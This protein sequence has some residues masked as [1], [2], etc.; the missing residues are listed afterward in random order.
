M[1]FKLRVLLLLSIVV[2]ASCENNKK[3]DP[4]V[5]KISQKNNLQIKENTTDDSSKMKEDVLFLIDTSKGTHVCLISEIINN[6]FDTSIIVDF[7]N[8]H[9][10]IEAHKASIIEGNY[11][12]DN[13]D[14]ITDITNDYYITNVNSKLRKFT[15][16][17]K[18][19]LFI[20]DFE[21]DGEFKKIS[22]TDFLRR[23]NDNIDFYELYTINFKNGKASR[24]EEIFVP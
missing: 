14:T 21:T 4:Q 7:V 13:G 10:G 16:S 5:S 12:I 2:F 9:T 8:Y 1:N 6:K 11:E 3:I 24:L 19:N 22:L 18:T 17:N 23:N 20:Y 15:V